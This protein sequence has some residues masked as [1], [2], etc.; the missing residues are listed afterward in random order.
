MLDCYATSSSLR[1]SERLLRHDQ[2]RR[3]SAGLH[4]AATT[5]VIS[6]ASIVMAYQVGREDVVHDHE[7]H[8]AA[9]LRL[10]PVQPI[11]PRQV[12]PLRP[13][14]GLQRASLPSRGTLNLTQ[15]LYRAPVF[16]LCVPCLHA[17]SCTVPAR[18]LVYRAC[19]LPRVSCTLH[20]P[21]LGLRSRLRSPR[22]CSRVCA[23]RAK[24]QIHVNLTSSSI[25]P[26]LII[27][28]IMIYSIVPS[29][30]NPPHPPPRGH[31]KGCRTGCCFTC[32]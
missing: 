10:P 23:G 16:P 25:L 27:R 21:S 14:Y 2:L 13:C 26:F 3:S 6:A 24:I 28:S 22:H 1:V 19:T 7:A 20:A 31:H 4:C 12:R 9:V 11:E 15:R 17:P 29:A 32:W 5:R 8:V 30:S 18:S